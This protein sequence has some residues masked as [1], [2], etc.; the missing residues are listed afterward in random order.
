MLKKILSVSALAVICGCSMVNAPVVGSSNVS[1]GDPNAVETVNTDFGSTDLNTVAQ[2]MADDLI[3]SGALNQ[4]QT[5]TVSPVRNKTDQYIDTENI[6]QS[7][8][9][10]L[11]KSNLVTAKYVLSQA[12]MQN[13]TDEL[14]RQNNSGLYKNP[15]AQGKMLAAQ[16]RLDG[17]VSNITKTNADVKDVFYQFNLSLIKVDEGEEIWANEKQIRKTEV[18]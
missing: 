5:Y 8:K 2:N 15:T 18:K 10:R 16:C 13:Q 17:F 6:T 9:V 4:C 3:K 12:Q 11:A 1:Y 7:I 14:A